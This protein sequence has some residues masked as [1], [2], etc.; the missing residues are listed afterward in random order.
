M[1]RLMDGWKAPEGVDPHESYALYQQECDR[2]IATV[3]GYRWSLG[4]H[5][6]GH[7]H[8]DVGVIT[9]AFY[10]TVLIVKCPYGEIAEHIVNLHNAGLPEDAVQPPLKVRCIDLS[11]EENLHKKY[12]L[13]VVERED[14]FLHLGRV[15]EVHEMNDTEYQIPVQVT[16]DEREMNERPTVGIPKEMFE[17]VKE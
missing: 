7:G 4:F 12:P 1:L 13:P 6:R 10:R 8:G 5:D 17:I 14:W 11:W 15:Y 16:E 9:R 3:M 2:R